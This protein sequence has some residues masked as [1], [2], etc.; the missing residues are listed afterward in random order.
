M[1]DHVC[2]QLRSQGVKTDTLRCADYAIAPGVEADMGDGDEWPKIRQRVI[3]A[4][5]LLLSTPV[6]LGHRPASPSA[7][8]SVATQTKDYKD[9]EKA[10]RSRRRWPPPRATPPSWPT[11]CEPSSIQ[12]TSDVTS[13]PMVANSST[14]ETSLKSGRGYGG[15]RSHEKPQRSRRPCQDDPAAC[16]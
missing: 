15:R 7:Y 9:L 14:V 4:D 6:W 1:A 2:E 8:S 13:Q 5:I 3:D 11:C 16:R 10:D 12:P